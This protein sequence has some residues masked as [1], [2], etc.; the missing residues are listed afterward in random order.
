MDGNPIQRPSQH[1]GL[2][3]SWGLNRCS[4]H[5]QL[6]TQATGNYT[7]ASA[8]NEDRDMRKGSRYLSELLDTRPDAPTWTVRWPGKASPPGVALDFW[9][10]LLSRC[11]DSGLPRSQAP[12]EGWAPSRH[13]FTPEGTHTF[14]RRHSLARTEVTS[15]SYVP[16]NCSPSQT[17]HSDRHGPSRLLET[18][19]FRG[20]LC[21][22]MAHARHCICW[23]ILTRPQITS[24]TTCCQ[25]LGGTG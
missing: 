9:E 12:S 15:L 2:P 24:S 20:T 3:S 18:R 14:L 19:Q 7:R 16:L 25:E 5:Q 23:K 1:W 13:P 11:E 4:Q 22:V 10:A 17:S 21:T 6:L 8:Q